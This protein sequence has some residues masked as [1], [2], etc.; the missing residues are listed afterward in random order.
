MKVKI[1]RRSGRPRV[2]AHYM[3]KV[4]RQYKISFHRFHHDRLRY[5]IHYIEDC[6]KMM[7]SSEKCLLPWLEPLAESSLV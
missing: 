5:G 1:P 6:T 7:H 3:V 2:E 4:E